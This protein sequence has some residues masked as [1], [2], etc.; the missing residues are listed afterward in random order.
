M[1]SERFRTRPM[2]VEDLT[3]TE[4]RMR[5]PEWYSSYE[6]ANRVLDKV[7]ALASQTKPT[8]DTWFAHFGIE[9]GELEKALTIGLMVLN[10]KKVRDAN[11]KR[12]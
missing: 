2:T 5:Q 9:E 6:T 1:S 12:K 4:R 3:N 11:P 7:S 10:K 8:R